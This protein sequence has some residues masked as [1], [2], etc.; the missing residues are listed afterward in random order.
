MGQLGG[1]NRNSGDTILNSQFCHWPLEAGSE[2]RSMNAGDTHDPKLEGLFAAH[3]Q[4]DNIGSPEDVENFR[5]WK[6]ES[7]IQAPPPR[8]LERPVRQ[9]RSL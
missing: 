8:P 2:T 3:G 5:F 1:T 7:Q 9:L 6:M 4:E